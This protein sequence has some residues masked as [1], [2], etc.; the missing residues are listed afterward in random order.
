MPLIKA[1]LEFGK[2]MYDDT[3]L[4]GIVHIEKIA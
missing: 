2:G 4:A 1:Q 3:K